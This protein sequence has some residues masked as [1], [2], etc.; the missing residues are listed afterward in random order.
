[1]FKRND[2]IDYE[3]PDKAE[4][5]IGSSVKVE[6]DFI[7][8][9]DVIVE[10]LVSGSLKT[11]KSLRV[12]EN[13]KII[14]NVSAGNALIAGEIQ[15]NLKIKESLELTATAKVFGDIKTN[16]LSV[17]PGAIIQGKCLIGEEKKSKPEK[18]DKIGKSKKE[19]E[20][21]E[22]IKY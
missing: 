20:N 18:I 16:T 21:E 13:A 1:M 3:N 22:I 17:A 19:E 8:E 10:G 4:T 2:Q 7:A 9:G 14:A 6:G 15:G 5:I 11:E 12:G